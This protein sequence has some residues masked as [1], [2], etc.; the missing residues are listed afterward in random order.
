MRGRLLVITKEPEFDS[1]GEVVLGQCEP[2]TSGWRLIMILPDNSREELIVGT[3]TD[4][5]KIQESCAGL[6]EPERVRKRVRDMRVLLV[7]SITETVIA[8]MDRGPADATET[9][10]LPAVVPKQTPGGLCDLAAN[11]SVLVATIV[12]PERAD[13]ENY[14]K[15]ELLT[16]LDWHPKAVLMDL[17]RVS[18]LSIGCFRELAGMRDRLQEAGAKFAL[19]SLTHAMHQKVQ[20][21]KS[22]DSI[23]VFESKSVALDALKP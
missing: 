13:D 8:P 9:R 21:M 5:R 22:K 12:Q 6:Q 23:S 15:K 17:S 18:N 10:E 19:C 1:R 11:G 20:T 16:L 14:L 7:S 2:F 4:L 3:Y